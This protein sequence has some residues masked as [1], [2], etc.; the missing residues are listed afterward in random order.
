MTKE[1]RKLSEE[2][3]KNR[4]QEIIDELED[5]ESEADTEKLEEESRSLTNQLKEMKKMKARNKLAEDI[6]NGVVEAEKVEVESEEARKQE[7]AKVEERANALREK[8]SITVSSNNLLTPNH[9]AK[10]INDTFTP[11]S[12]LIDNA[13]VENL[14][15]GESYQEAY[16]KTYG[17]GGQTDEGGNYTSSGTEPTF[18]YADINK[19][20]VTAYA[21]ISEEAEK[22]PA[23]N[24]VEKVEK[25]MTIALKKK[26]VEYMLNGT[27]NKQFMGIF[28]NTQEITG[29]TDVTASA[30]NNQ[31]LDDIIFAYGSDEDTEEDAVL[32]LSKADL[33]AFS[34]V[35]TN[36]GKKFYD[37]DTKNKTIDG[38]P[39]IISSQCHPVS[40]TGETVGTYN[41][42]AYGSLKNY[43]IAIFSDM[44][45]SKSTDYKFK[46]GMTCYKSSVMA[47][48]NVVKYQGFVRVNKVV[49]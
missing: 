19:V 49:A 32:I 17:T 44:E 2:E 20:K 35:R 37:I 16:V 5:E 45:V 38:I 28:K 46:E 29:V 36:D 21:E 33:K 43:K 42:M 3:I 31:T 6:N 27:G 34:K 41:C 24:Y 1:E 22:L 39:Y 14:D 48:G 12:R 40:A 13:D 10:E 30:I 4:L 9:Q 15:G 8:R 25:N 26:M 47:G 23:Q 11:V 7:L 18:G